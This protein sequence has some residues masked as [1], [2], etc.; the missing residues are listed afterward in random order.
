[1]FIL[2]SGCAEERQIYDIGTPY[3]GEG[4]CILCPESRTGLLLRIPVVANLDNYTA[5]AK[6]KRRMSLPWYL[7]PKINLAIEGERIRKAREVEDGK[8]QDQK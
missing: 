4:S 2:C 7:N 5:S 1:M 3:N 8:D 6:A